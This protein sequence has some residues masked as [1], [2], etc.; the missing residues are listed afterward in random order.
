MRKVILGLLVVFAFNTNAQKTETTFIQKIEGKTKQEIFSS[1]NKWVAL[2]YNSAMDVIQLSDVVGGSIVVKGINIL[3][4]P[5]TIGKAILSNNPYVLDNMEV[6][7]N[8]VL[9]FSIKDGKYRLT[10]SFEKIDGGKVILSPLTEEVKKQRLASPA[11]FPFTS[12]RKELIYA[13]IM[14]NMVEDERLA[15]INFIEKTNNVVLEG[16]ISNQLDEDW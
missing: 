15:I 6:K 13:K 8:H 7:L 1:I 16:V 2:N 12:K 11:K 10:F 5:N 4:V 9:D 3:I 14:L